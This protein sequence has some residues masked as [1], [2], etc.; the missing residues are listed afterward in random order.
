MELSGAAV[1]PGRTVS[2]AEG[3]PPMATSP[4]VHSYRRHPKNALL[5]ERQ[6]R[7]KKRAAHLKGLNKS[8]HRFESSRHV[9]VYSATRMK[10]F[11]RP[12]IF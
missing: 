10:A 12:F 8:E 5:G 4:P 9:R 3:C 6:P 11:L 2:C 1:L 7:E